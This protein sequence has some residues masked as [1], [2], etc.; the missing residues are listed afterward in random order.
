MIISNSILTKM[1]NTIKG[2]VPAKTTMPILQNLLVRDEY[3]IASNTEMTVMVKLEGAGDEKMLLP[4]KAYNLITSLGNEDIE[5]TSDAKHSIKIRYGNSVSKFASHNPDLY[6]YMCEKLDNASPAAVIDAE[7]LKNGIKRTIWAASKEKSN[8]IFESMNFKSCE[9]NLEICGLCRA[10]VAVT[11]IPFNGELNVLLPRYAAEKLLTLDF[12]GP[13][14]I[15]HNKSHASFVSQKMIFQ[16]R[17]S[18]GKFVEYKNMF[19]DL[20]EHL[21]MDKM[22]LTKILKRII[23][24]GDDTLPAKL[25]FSGNK[26]NISYD[27]ALTEFSETTEFDRSVSDEILA[28]FNPRIL[29]DLISAYQDDEININIQSGSMPMIVSSEDEMQKSMILPIKL[30]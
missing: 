11:K 12:S 14:A 30:S 17:I 26:L 6:T 2:F 23:I 20:K 15:S 16:T 5:V 3:L 24:I 10:A 13:V 8:T 1:I 22:D 21:T 19:G 9:G 18:D 4:P 29:L 27:S 7:A 25:L 28:G